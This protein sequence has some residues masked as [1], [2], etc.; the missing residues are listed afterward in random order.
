MTKCT[1]LSKLKNI[2]REI[3][4]LTSDEAV[5]TAKSFIPFLYTNQTR[6]YKTGNFVV[7]NMKLKNVGF[8]LSSIFKLL[9]I[10]LP[11]LH[12]ISVKMNMMFQQGQPEFFK[13]QI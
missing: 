7:V 8:I 13:D 11:L 12:Q 3:R 10:C 9:K 2:P 6:K 5:P 1:K 4:Q